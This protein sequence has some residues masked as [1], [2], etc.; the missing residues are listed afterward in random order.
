MFLALLLFAIA[1]QAN[2]VVKFKQGTDAEEFARAN[3]LEYLGPFPVLPDYYV[4]KAR[5]SKSARRIM[6]SPHVEWA[7]EQH[8]RPRV[9]PRVGIDPMY[10]RQWHL[11]T[12]PIA[13]DTDRIPLNLTGKDIT[14][15]IVD[16]GLQHIHPDISPNYV[17]LHSYNFNAEKADPAPGNSGDS[18][19][20][21]AAGVAAAARF[22]NYC[23]RGVAPEAKIAGIRVIAEPVSDM[24]EAQA[25]T[26]HVMGNIDIVSCSWGPDDDGATMSGPGLLTERAMALY[27]GGLRGRMGRGTIYVWAAG[28]GRDSADSCAFDGYASSPYAFAIGALDRRG[29][30]SWYS[31]GC[32]ALLAVT[33]SSG[34][35]AGIVTC[36][37]LGQAGYSP[38]DCTDQFG[39]TSAAAPMAAGVIAIMLQK[40][41]ELTWRD[42]KHIIAKYATQIQNA[43]SDWHINAAGYHHSHNYGFGLLKL[44]PLLHGVEVHE[45]VP[46]QFKLWNSGMQIVHMPN[47]YIPYSFDIAVNNSGIHFVEHVQLT[48]S[49]DHTNRGSITIELRSPE[50]TISK[51]AEE[52]PFDRNHNYPSGGW[53]FTSIRHWGETRADGIWHVTIGDT[54]PRTSGKN[55]FHGYIFKV[56]GM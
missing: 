27:A 36:D 31:E 32:A 19:G 40:R 20:T 8:M 13:L 1:V 46:P 35:G 34:N 43:D 9:F 10:E 5:K 18:H 22:N 49:L 23:G 11:H 21:A 53:T 25:L 28:N 54:N 37:L 47:G 17:A 16:D 7:E 52:R 29:E 2:W 6:E 24:V 38:N 42:V 4:F 45:L 51:L 56:M 14:I 33:P 39:G 44:G 12:S 26:Y 50:G 41:P 48:C 55:H 3:E 30:R 15:A